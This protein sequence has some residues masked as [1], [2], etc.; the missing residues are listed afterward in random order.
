MNKFS[1]IAISLSPNTQYD[2]VAAAFRALFIIGNWRT[3][4]NIHKAKVWLQKYLGN[5]N[6][7]LFNSGR[8]AL[9]CLL[10]S[11][12]IKKDDQ[13]IIQAF[14]CAAVP[15][16]VIWLGAKP[17]YADIDDSLN[18]DYK[19][20][21]QLINEKTKA[22]IVQHTFGIP[23]QIEKIKYIAQKHKL[24]FIEDCSHSLGGSY[25]GHKLGTIADAAIFSFG[26]DKVIS[27]VFGGA[28]VINT[29]DKTVIRSMREIYSG[30]QVPGRIWIIRQL[31]HPILFFFILP[32]YN[33]SI[34]KILI[35]TFQ[36]LKILSK[37]VEK[38]ELAAEKPTDFPA[39]LP[40][41][42]AFLLLNQFK[43]LDKFNAARVW[44]ALIYRRLMKNQQNI[45][46]PVSIE[47]SIY[48]RFNVLVDKRD[49]LLYYLKS[50]KILAGNWYH[51]VIDPE[52]VDYSAFAFKKG[53]L[54]MAE[55]AARQSLNL[56]TY[57]GL[58]DYDIK[59]IVDLISEYENKSS[60][61]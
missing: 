44:A 41:A 52:G 21:E 57:Y 36:K 10:M 61:R 43:K 54:K 4:A 35:V 60:Y 40:D 30:L 13:V 7:F 6:I 58:T 50:K 29:R 56:P 2:D 1:P 51:N 26:R 18:I 11:L 19:S 45:I 59:K 15:E 47:G 12:G 22:I 48:L 33:I 9:Y 20:L 53:T 28:A 5:K 27:C 17:V 42:L 46:L 49:S 39:K 24:I 16:P 23:A 38:K 25:R 8:S 31:L 14:T 32:L 34:G 3:G 55:K 37:P